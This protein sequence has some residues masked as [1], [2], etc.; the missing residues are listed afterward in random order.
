MT[1]FKDINLDEITDL[2]T[3]KSVIKI[4]LSQIQ[5]LEE[6]ISVLEKNS[7]NS[8]KPPSSDITKPNSQQRHPGKRKAGG[9]SRHPGFKHKLIPEDKV[10][11][12]K[13]VE[14]D[15]CPCCSGVLVKNGKTKISQQYEF[16]EKPVALTQYK[17]IGYQCINCNKNLYPQIPTSITGDKLQAGISYFK[18]AL[19][20]SYTE[21]QELLKDLFNVELS[22]ASICNIIKNTTKCLKSSHEDLNTHIK[23]SESINCD[24][25][26]WNN[27]GKNWWMWVFTTKQYSLFKLSNSRGSSVIE[28]VLGL[29]Y[30][31]A[32]T[33]DF[34][35]A[36]RKFKFKNQQYCL[37]HLIRDIKFLVTFPEEETVRFSTKLLSYFKKLFEHW[38]VRD[39]LGDN[40]IVKVQRLK[41]RL[42]NF[43]Y[44]TTLKKGKARTLKRRIINRWDNLFKFVDNP[45][46]FS[47]TNN[48]AEQTIRFLVRVRALTQGSRGTWG[49][50]WIERST[51]VV[52]SCRKQKRSIY[53][54]YLD[55]IIA[56]K[57]NSTF[58]SL[59]SVA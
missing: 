34:Y 1:D 45:K 24:E 22:R 42:K 10:D 9:Q 5:K 12:F 17:A 15:S 16:V 40:F 23:Q 3:A 33:S 18:S 54:F 7:S 31:G 50:T 26:G 11:N 13:D 4:L 55:T 59:I 56:A 58:P 43:L 29:D 57:N 32:I 44:R 27:Q 47:P 48:L 21:I 39:T 53:K 25:T 38:H 51:S 37:A 2:D 30:K 49:T 41:V 28:D 8:S 46:L 36:Y 35:G 20:I 6:R 19:G 52:A 14:L